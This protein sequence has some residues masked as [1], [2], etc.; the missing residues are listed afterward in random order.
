M[1]IEMGYG[2][3]NA[4]AD[5]LGA[6]MQK[7]SMDG[8][9]DYA[10]K[11]NKRIDDETGPKPIRAA[12]PSHN[13]TVTP[14]IADQLAPISFGGVQP[15]SSGLAGAIENY[16]PANGGPSVYQAMQQMANHNPQ[17]DMAPA[18]QLSPDEKAAQQA[19]YNDFAAAKAANPQWYVGDTYVGDDANAK[20][21]AQAQQLAAQQAKQQAQANQYGTDAF[22]RDSGQ[23]A[24][25][26]KFGFTGESTAPLSYSDFVSRTKKLKTTAMKEMI[27]KYGV[28]AAKQAES[29][30]D[31]AITEKNSAYGDQI[32]AQNRS[33]LGKF[34]LNGN[35]NTPT[36]TRQA[37]WATVEYNKRA[38]AMGKPTVDTAMLGKM[39][40]AGKISI[41][42]KDT[43][44]SINFYAAPK[45]GGLFDDGTALK[46]ILVQG[47]TLS[48][49]QVVNAKQKE[50]QM[51]E[52][53]RH[54]RVTESISAS[55]ASRA[56]GGSRGGR[57]SGGSSKAP[58]IGYRKIADTLQYKKEAAISSIK[59]GDA[60]NNEDDHSVEEYRKAC[61]DALQ[62][63]QLD[64]D[65]KAA[66]QQD[67]EEV[68]GLYQDSL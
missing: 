67:M 37:L 60:A 20:K 43:G 9:M 26:N 44:G 21:S 24:F 33:A 7:Q 42:A 49:G 41:T 3:W 6:Y 46:P 52:T 32:D 53:A 63:G 40:D 39:L 2:P 59:S 36:G 19:K 17:G 50:I 56:G 64:D 65:D 66:V 12:A 51:A 28:N 22:N 68:Y 38:Q 31:S 54:N 62:S 23:Q 4:L 10:D 5:V 58:S 8:A 45:N 48:P 27:S 34:L 13:M 55:R 47:K 57:S 11:F 29:L 61:V 14:Q 1:V 25:N 35:I 15:A 16:Q 18:P 30:I